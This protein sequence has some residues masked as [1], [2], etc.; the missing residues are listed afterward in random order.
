[1]PRLWPS[2]VAPLDG[3]LIVIVGTQAIS[4][5]EKFLRV[6]SGTREAGG[7]LLGYRR[8]PHIEI[9]AATLPA[10]GDQRRRFS[11]VRAGCSH[12]RAA[13]R[14]WRDSEHRVDYVGEWHTHPES[15]PS[16]SAVDR[17]ELVRRSIEHRDDF[18]VELILG[19]DAVWFGMAGRKHYVPLKAI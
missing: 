19:F 16:P 10:R 3:S 11:F 12:Q 1:M 13:T 2:A 8:D 5:I 17:H 18:L 14:A 9:L 7:I 4:Q 6:D 15:N